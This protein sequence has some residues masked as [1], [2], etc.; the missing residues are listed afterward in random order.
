MSR[1]AETYGVADMTLEEINA[2][3]TAARNEV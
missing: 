2:E 3:I 1:L